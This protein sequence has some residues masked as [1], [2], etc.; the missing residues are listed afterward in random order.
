MKPGKTVVRSRRSRTAVG[1]ITGNG[2]GP[3]IT[4]AGTLASASAAASASF[5]TASIA[6]QIANA[7]AGEIGISPPGIDN[8]VDD[9][10]RMPEG[11]ESEE[12]NR[13][14]R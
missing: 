2:I 8:I 1:D 4:A 9:G 3:L 13:R 12:E 6:Q 10:I 5:G 11:Q 7:F 14:R